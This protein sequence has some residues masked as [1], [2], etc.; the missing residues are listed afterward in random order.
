MELNETF[1]TRSLRAHPQGRA[2]ARILAS[3]INA[4]AADE[5]VRRFAHRE[6]R[7]LVIARSAENESLAQCYDLGEVRRVLIFGLGKA[8]AAMSGAMAAMLEDKVP[9]GLLIVKHLV[10]SLP[11]GFE[12]VVG[13]HPIPNGGS[14]LGAQKLKSFV[15]G[16]TADDLLI[17]LISGGG[18]ALIT[19]PLPGVSL[20]DMQTLTASLLACGARIDEINTLRRHLDAVKGGG[21]AQMTAPARVISL[22]LSDVVGS[23]LEAIASGPTAPD[24][25]S[26]RDAL[27]I[28]E[29]YELMEKTPLAIVR[30]LQTAPETPKPGSSLFES[31]NN[32][33]VGDN[34]LA[35]Q[36]ALHQA[37]LEGFN[38]YYLRGDLQGEAR[39][40]GAEL[41]QYLMSV[42]QTN[43][44]VERPFCIVAGGETTVTVHGN[45]RGGRNQELALAAVTE[46]ADLPG[47]LLVSLAT[48]G[49][50]G[51]T[52]AAGAVVSGET[53]LRGKEAGLNPEDYLADNNA[54]AYFSALGDLLKPGPTGTN[55]NDLAFLFGF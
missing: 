2:V 4:V 53:F 19:S 49:E 33:I 39:V 50:D 55:V 32:V 34:L 51:P 37:R 27:A 30:S 6:G 31:V 45:G 23:P 1:L 38:T 7:Q 29:K 46:L 21:L 47:S 14:L 25:S 43:Q 20:E 54:Y 22:I 10:A 13:G 36:A 18:S 16:C 24:W 48:D 9:R 11:N 40:V 17:C 15:K 35:A 52:D 41:C 3:G 5:A 8:A 44:P 26:S 42:L 28:L 12:Q